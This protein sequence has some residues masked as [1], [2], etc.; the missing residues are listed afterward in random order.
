MLISLP[1]WVLVMVLVFLYISTYIL[2][3][4]LWIWPLVLSTLVFRTCLIVGGLP[5]WLSNKECASE[6]R[7]CRFNPR[8]W[9]ISWRRAWQ[10]TP[11]FLHGEFHGQKS[12]VGYSPWGRKELDMTEQLSM[13]AI[14]PPTNLTLKIWT[15][16]LISKGI[17]SKICHSKF[18]SQ[19]NFILDS[20]Q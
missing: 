19:N 2:Y 17:L 9:K 6:C 3:M 7:R 5:P 20:T 4:S 13:H 18:P 12:L 11:V 16:S 14:M 8:V 1:L 10:P 15:I